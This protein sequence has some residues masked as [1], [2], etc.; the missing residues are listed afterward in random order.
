MINKKL[1]ATLLTV[2]PCMM[3]AELLLVDKIE[4]VACGPERNTPFVET[5]ASWKRGLDGQ[6]IPLQQQLQQEIVNQ[7]IIADKMPLDPTLA[8]KYIEGMKKQNN[9]SDDDLANLFAEIGRTFQEGVGLLSNQYTHEMFVQHKFK[10][11]LVPTEENILAYYNENPMYEQGWCELVVASV[12]Y[13][14]DSKQ[15]VKEKVDQF[16]DGKEAKDFAVEWS[17]VIKIHHTDLADDKKFILE[18]KPEQIVV[19]DTN[20]AFELYKLVDKKETQLKTVDECRS[21]ISD[22]LNRKKFEEMLQNYN[23]EIRKF[24]DVINLNENIMI[25]K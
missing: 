7:Q 12:S 6:L 15:A 17:S 16:L 5:D 24:V 22:R 8:D 1:L 19:Q 3:Q 20:G 23:E 21:L 25:Q 9:L 2:L 4:C 10:S 14:D 11:Q 18:M 13:V